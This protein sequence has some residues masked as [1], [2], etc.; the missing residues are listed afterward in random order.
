MENLNRAKMLF[1]VLIYA[2]KKQI[3]FS[4]VDRIFINQERAQLMANETAKEIG[5]SPTF[6]NEFKHS[7]A[8]NGKINFLIVKIQ[9][10]VTIQNQILSQM[11]EVL[12]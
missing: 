5:E 6:P 11:N 1:A 9:N 2:T 12:K 4:V 7:K 10:D 8:L 3:N